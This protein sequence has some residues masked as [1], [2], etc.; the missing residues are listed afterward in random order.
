MA[1]R[2]S[3]LDRLSIIV[4]IGVFVMA[5]FGWLPLGILGGQAS[6][7]PTWSTCGKDLCMCAP[8]PCCP[9]CGGEPTCVKVNLSDTERSDAVISTVDSIVAILAQ[10]TRLS[11][12]IEDDPG[13]AR[14]TG[15]VSLHTRAL[16]VPSPPP[17]A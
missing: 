17:R 3:T 7:I 11:G 10:P 13:A 5:Q 8:V 1:P 14:L 4:V 15:N 9:L 12:Q 2:P 16:G 6:V